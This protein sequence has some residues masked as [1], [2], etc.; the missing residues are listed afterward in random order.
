MSAD[1][2]RRILDLLT[3][4]RALWYSLDEETQRALTVAPGTNDKCS[5]RD[6][7]DA[8]AAHVRAALGAGHPV[9]R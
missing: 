5:L 3:E 2:L 1:E 7:L 4:A 8:A 9:P 6:D